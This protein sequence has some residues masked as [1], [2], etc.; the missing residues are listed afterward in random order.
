MTN[1]TTSTRLAAIAGIATLGLALAGCTRTLQFEGA[2]HYG[3]LMTADNADIADDN[4]REQ[5]LSLASAY[6]LETSYAGEE[7]LRFVAQAPSYTVTQPDG[8]VEERADTRLVRVEVRFGEE[9]GENAY[10]YYCWVEGEEPFHFDDEDRARFALALLAVREIF[11][12][13]IATD[14]LGN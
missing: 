1:A 6:G 8:A 12:K 14:F 10:R 13:P 4:A 3:N 2:L 7:I 5:V 9:L 11:E